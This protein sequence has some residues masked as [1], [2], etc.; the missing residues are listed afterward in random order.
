MKRKA[1]SLAFILSLL[2][3][4]AALHIIDSTVV[5]G[6]VPNFFPVPLRVSID[7]LNSSKVY[8]PDSKIVLT[9][10]VSKDIGAAF[11]YVLYPSKECFRYSLDDNENVTGEPKKISRSVSVLTRHRRR[12]TQIETT[13]YRVTINLLGASE[14][15]HKISVYIGIGFFWPRA[16]YPSMSDYHA[17]P[18]IYFNVT[19]PEI[20]EK[21]TPSPTLT[22]PELVDTI[23]GV[24]IVVVVIVAGVGLLVYFKKRKH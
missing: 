10:N 24:V 18:S 2:M 17:Q 23:L 22:T 13:R 16:P 12:P 3:S 14:G 1:L 9:F 7:E 15:Q 4:M 6:Q 19:S 20:A 5:D 21:P 11:S 8:K